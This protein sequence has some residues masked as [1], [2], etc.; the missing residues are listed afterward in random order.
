MDPEVVITS[1]TPALKLT[2]LTLAVLLLAG[3]VA[4]YF[5]KAD[6]T[7][8]TSS[9]TSDPVTN[10]QQ[11]DVFAPNPMIAPT[12]SL[13]V[14]TT[15][16]N[17]MRG[18]DMEVLFPQI[19]HLLP[20]DSKAYSIGYN[21]AVDFFSDGQ[22]ELLAIYTASDESL[23]VVV[24]SHD[25]GEYKTVTTIAD[26]SIKYLYMIRPALFD[27]GDVVLMAGQSKQGKALAFLLYGDKSTNEVRRYNLPITGEVSGSASIDAA[28]TTLL[29]EQYL[30]RPPN[31]V[32]HYLQHIK[33]GFISDISITKYKFTG[34]VLS[35][36]SPSPVRIDEG[37][38]A[39]KDPQSMVARGNSTLYHMIFGTDGEEGNGNHY[40][41]GVEPYS[42]LTGGQE[43]IV[44]IPGLDTLVARNT[45]EN[46]ATELE[47]RLKGFNLE[48]LGQYGDNFI[49]LT[50]AQKMGN[51]QYRLQV[52][53]NF[54]DLSRYYPF[55]YSLRFTL[56]IIDPGLAGT[57]PTYVGSGPCVFVK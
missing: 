44:T 45:I 32:H 4:Y 57:N 11:D 18:I 55:I 40:I 41:N 6:R 17:M 38:I 14:S 46:I 29:T 37:Q 25:S 30:I 54:G 31:E 49:P 42:T 33:P 5:V 3:V 13:P 48:V 35:E 12:Y 27:N 26:P 22:N 47:F 21:G 53:Q 51:D 52:P 28:L 34:G 8:S 10:V 7:S 1:I 50:I 15:E 36:L 43:F 16:T 2:V 56:N 9:D 20:A 39:C 19:Q 24:F 23:S